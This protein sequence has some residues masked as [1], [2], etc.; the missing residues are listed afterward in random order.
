M[1]ARTRDRTQ[2]AMNRLKASKTIVVDVETSGLDW[3]KQHVVGWALAF[4]PAPQDAYYLPVRHAPGGNIGGAKGPTTAFNW[5]GKPHKIEKDIIKNLDQQG[6]TLIFHHANFD[7]RFMSRLGFQFKP[8][9]EDTF[10]MAALID[11]W[12]GKFS[13]AACAARAGVQAKK[14]DEIKDHIRKKFPET[15]D[16]N[17]MG[18]YWRLA[19]DDPLGVSYATGDGTTTWQLRDKQLPELEKQDLMRVWDVE[20][21]LIP[22]LARMSARGIKIDEGRLAHVCRWLKEQV[23]DGSINFP[24]RLM[25]PFRRESKEF[26]VRS[27]GDV[28]WWMER[29]GHTDWPRTPASTRFP[30]GQPSFTES[31]LENYP[32]GQQIVQVRRLCTLRDTF[33]L[34]LQTEHLWKG[35]VH[36]TFNQLRGDEYGTITGRLSCSEPNLQA[37]PMHKED[38]SRMFLQMFVPDEGMTWGHSDFSQ[39]EPRLLAYYSRCRVLM[40]G[41]RA[42]P[43][44]DAHTAVA[45]VANKNW[46]GMDAA[47][48]KQYRNEV[49]K[50][51]NMTVVTGGGKGVLVRKYKMK[52]TEVDKFWNDYHR[53]LPEVR[54]IQKRME[55]RMRQRGYILTA[56]GRRCRLLDLSK[57]YV[58]INRALQGSNADLIKLKLV[59]CDEYLASVGRPIDILNTVHDSIDFQFPK[60]GRSAYGACLEIMADCGEQAAIKLDVPIVV[61]HGEGDSWATAAHGE[62]K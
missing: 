55:A 44:I 37:T 16:K 28:Q 3:R 41:Y 15:T 54:S 59:E 17:Y 10:I 46:P 4:G 49:A 14:S 39:L 57:A 48:R 50:R 33:V 30:D 53:A 24:G 51:I 31:W 29:H 40:D 61:D 1:L 32:A 35:R 45:Q 20:S 56:L 5:D 25:E 26:N 34:P 12:A 43:P 47:A 62:E 52:E 36:T 38:V 60:K 19:G 13:L 23:G 11:E 21:R 27:P 22:V 42:D 7:L 2:E 18:S 8:R 6:K 58:A 9:H